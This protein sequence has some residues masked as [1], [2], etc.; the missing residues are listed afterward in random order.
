MPELTGFYLVG[1]TSLGLQLGHRNSIDIDLFSQHEFEDQFIID[2]ITKKYVFLEKFRRKNTIIGF[3][4]DIKVDFICHPYP[5]VKEPISEEGIT[6][7]SKED[8][9]AM[10]LNA[11]AGSGQRLKDFIDVYFL[12]ESLSVNDM[13]ECYSIKY[14]NS[15]PMIAL[16]AISYFE[17]IDPD[18]DPPKMKTPLSLKKIK[19][20]ITEAVLHQYK[21][22]KE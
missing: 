3:I 9:A 19:K 16:K 12:L 22:F 17:D 20:R 7:L 14:P 15:N 4:H 8:I 6:Y 1:G 13:L 5:L 10:K 11:I 21:T 18:I 2:C